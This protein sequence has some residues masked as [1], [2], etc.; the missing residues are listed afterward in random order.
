MARNVPRELRRSMSADHVDQFAGPR[1]RR[2]RFRARVHW[3]VQFHRHDMQDMPATE[4]KDVSSD[5]FYVLSR[6]RFAPGELV[7]C[8]LRIPAHRPLSPGGT[9]PVRCK[10]RIIRV[11]DADSRGFH[12]LGCRIEDYQFPPVVPPTG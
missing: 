2:R 11:E 5:G 1:E 8:T 7:D 3:P 4:T 12:G 10:V 9:V 6:T